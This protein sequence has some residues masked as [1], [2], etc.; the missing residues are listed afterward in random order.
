MVLSADP[1]ILLCLP[2]IEDLFIIFALFEVLNKV[3][4][5]CCHL[6]FVL[7]KQKLFFKI[8]HLCSLTQLSNITIDYLIRPRNDAN[9]T[10]FINYLKI[11]TK[12]SLVSKTQRQE[13]NV[14]S[15]S[16]GCNSFSNLKEWIVSIERLMLY[17]LFYQLSVFYQICALSHVCF[18]RSAGV[19]YITEVS[20]KCNFPFSEVL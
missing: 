4:F 14:W 5:N 15:H 20:S 9:S 13:W 7:E 2:P 3:L 1:Y 17:P 16:P 8:N 6:I 18:I 19:R 12:S 10:C 11:N